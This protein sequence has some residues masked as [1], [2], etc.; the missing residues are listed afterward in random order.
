MQTEQKEERYLRAAVM[1]SSHAARGLL[2]KLE[3]ITGFCAWTLKSLQIEVH[4]EN[5]LN[6]TISFNR[7][8]SVHSLA[9]Y[10][11]G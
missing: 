4:M 7:R 11:Q 10:N 8:F 1:E 9:D 3:I 6:S 2:Y 5:K